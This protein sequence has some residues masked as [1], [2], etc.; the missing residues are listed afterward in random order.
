MSTNNL[1]EC[2]WDSVTVVG[3]FQVLHFDFCELGYQMIL[4]YQKWDYPWLHLRQ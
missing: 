4:K 1:S 2:K 3:R